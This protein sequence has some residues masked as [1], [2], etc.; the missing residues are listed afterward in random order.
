MTNENPYASPAA[1][2][3]VASSVIYPAI[4]APRRVTLIDLGITLA[5]LI[6]AIGVRQ[7][8]SRSDWWPSHHGDPNVL[9]NHV[10]VL[11]QIPFQAIGL[12]IL[13]RA[14]RYSSMPRAWEWLPLMVCIGYWPQQFRDPYRFVNFGDDTVIIQM[15]SWLLLLVIALFLGSVLYLLFAKRLSPILRILAFLFLCWIVMKEF[16][17]AVMDLVMYT[18]SYGPLHARYDL[19][20]IPTTTVLILLTLVPWLTGYATPL[21]AGLRDWRRSHRWGEWAGL[22]YGLILLEFGFFIML[23]SL[24]RFYFALLI[25]GA[26]LLFS[27]VILINRKRL[28]RLLAL[29]DSSPPPTSQKT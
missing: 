15:R 20:S 3:P 12:A 28:T 27:L 10:Y 2:P 19:E 17:Q 6:V 26:V 9:R 5:G 11:L 14:W 7:L 1:E 18:E 23:D 13:A 16:A 24:H 8:F 4:E 25:V 21:L 22:A 29:E